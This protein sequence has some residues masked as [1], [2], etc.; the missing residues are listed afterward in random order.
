MRFLRLRVDAVFVNFLLIL[1]CNKY[2]EILKVI[3]IGV[4]IPVKHRLY[5]L[6]FLFPVASHFQFTFPVIQ[7][8]TM[9]PSV[10]QNLAVILSCSSLISSLRMKTTVNSRFVCPGTNGNLIPTKM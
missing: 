4:N 2:L 1:S 3:K 10:G 7:Q 5:R 9:A 6:S 8:H